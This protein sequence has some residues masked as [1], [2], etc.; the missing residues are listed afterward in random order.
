MHTSQNIAAEHLTHP[1][2]SIGHIKTMHFMAA[3]LSCKYEMAP[4]Y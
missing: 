1:P 2:E 4:E 3:S